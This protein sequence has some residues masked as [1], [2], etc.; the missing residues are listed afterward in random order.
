MASN[1]ITLKVYP[2]GFLGSDTA[3]LT[4]PIPLAQIRDQIINMTAAAT[5]DT[6]TANQDIISLYMASVGKPDV[7]RS[8]E[9]KEKVLTQALKAFGV[10][11]IYV[12]LT[13]QRDSVYWSN[14]HADWIDETLGYIY[15]GRARR[16]V[17]GIW[18]R[19]LNVPENVGGPEKPSPLMLELY[20]RDG[21][22]G[23]NRD[24]SLTKFIHDWV[25]CENGFDD[26]LN[27]LNL[28]FGK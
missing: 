2:S 16:Y 6:R 23:T 9:Y 21:K 4:R 25:S 26:L 3:S 13:V 15:K 17:G 24:T 28:I 8:F 20:G 11:D 5:P 14:A 10:D 1:D 12:W 27:S 22:S 19:S 18:R 7:F